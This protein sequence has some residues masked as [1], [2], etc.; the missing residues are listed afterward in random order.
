M[1]YLVAIKDIDKKE[2]ETIFNESIEIGKW[3]FK[4]NKHS[5]YKKIKNSDKIVI[6]KSGITG[7]YFIGEFEIDGEV[8][9]NNEDIKFFQIF[10]FCVNI[11]KVKLYNKKIILKE[12]KDNF[13]F[14]KNKD[15]YGSALQRGNVKLDLKDYD[16][17]INILEGEENK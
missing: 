4:E 6:Y 16:F 9:K 15:N 17:L 11:K 14:I 8:E 12:Y 10:N 7:G 2:A 5:V 1:I 13:D 3:F